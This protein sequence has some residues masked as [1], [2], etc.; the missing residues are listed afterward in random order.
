MEEILSK[1][2]Y[3]PEGYQQTA[4][5]LLAAAKKEGHKFAPDKVVHWLRRQ[6]IWQIY[7]PPPRYVPRPPFQ[8]DGPNRVHQADLLF[9]PHDKVGRKVYKYALT[10]VDVS[11]RYKAAIPLTDKTA[12]QA[13]AAFKKTYDDKKNP[14][15]WPQLLQVDEGKEFMAGVKRLMSSHKVGIRR[16]EVGNHRAQGIVEAFNRRLAERLFRPQYAQELLFV[17]TSGAAGQERSTEWVK[18]LPSVLAE[19]NTSTTRLLGISPSEA[20]Q[21]KSNASAAGNPL[22]PGRP[23]GFQEPRLPSNVNV[24]YLLAPGEL[25]GGRRRATDP[26]WSLSVHRIV[27]SVAQKDRPVLYYISNGPLRS[28]V[29][30]ELQVVPTD[31]QLPPSKQ[32]ARR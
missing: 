16:G 24:R 5:H 17:E 2:Y 20:I 25:E 9:L 22:P 10:I 26:I 11:S 32:T 27:Q 12:A 14:L 1:L 4:S 31:T 8:E 18:Q 28:F 30:E 7:A 23:F 19:M 21:K 15:T 6:A 13:A 29:R 3:R